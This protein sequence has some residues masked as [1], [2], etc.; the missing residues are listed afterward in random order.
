MGL[1]AQV[2]LCVS[3]LAAA[4]AHTAGERPVPSSPAY[5]RA[6]MRDLARE[7]LNAYFRWR[8]EDATYF[9]FPGADHGAVQDPSPSALQAWHAAE[10]RFLARARALDPATLAGTREGDAHRVLTEV[11]EASQDARAC[12]LELWAVSAAHGW[13]R[14]YASVARYQPTGTP[15][16]RQAAVSRVSALSR[17]LDG[18]IANLREGV[19]FGFLA[20]RD[21]VV[22]VVEELDRLLATPPER[23]PQANPRRPDDDPAFRAALVAAIERDL[24]PAAARYNA[25]LRD[26]YLVIAGALDGFA[27]RT[28]SPL[29]LPGGDRCE[30]AASRLLRVLELEPSDLHASRVAR[31]QALPYALLDAAEV[32]PSV[33]VNCGTFLHFAGRYQAS[34]RAYDRA[35]D[36]VLAVPDP[37]VSV[38]LVVRNTALALVRMRNYDEARTRL[39]RYLAGAPRDAATTVILALVEVDTNHLEAA[40]AAARRA[41]TVDPRLSRGH[42][43]LG[44]VAEKRGQLP[45][46]LDSFTTAARLDPADPL[47]IYSSGRIKEKQGHIAEACDLYGRARTVLVQSS[48]AKSAVAAY[49]RL[50]RGREPR[51]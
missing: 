1:R 3:L 31:A 42:Q 34:V 25:Y 36:R 6:E 27:R 11:L 43:I 10:D 21:E 24:I 26:E 51:P 17:R 48:A 46:A 50:C 12:R 33:W 19:R 32:E 39:E 20:T 4:C 38:E 7:Y 30:R 45:T 44:Q 37:D 2:A 18:E 23:W 40:E 14:E 49:D 29:A 13:H 16:Y 28:A 47:P 5:A 8:P 35:Y 22:K 9:W 15:A 41:L